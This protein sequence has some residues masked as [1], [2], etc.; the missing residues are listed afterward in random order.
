MLRFRKRARISSEVFSGGLA[1]IDAR[2]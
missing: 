1:S 2:G